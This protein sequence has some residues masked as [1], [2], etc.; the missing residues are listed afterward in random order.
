MLVSVEEI[1]TAT[2]SLVEFLVDQ[3]RSGS[4]RPSQREGFWQ[5][6]TRKAGFQLAHDLPIHSLIADE[7]PQSGLVPI[8]ADVAW[9]GSGFTQNR[10]VTHSGGVANSLPCLCRM[11]C[12]CPHA[13]PARDSCS[14]VSY[15]RNQQFR[16]QLMR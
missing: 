3:L 13:V 1:V 12:L 5:I 11:S 8:N 4:F 15:A 7:W 2:P 9:E 14:E 16:A 10:R 6:R